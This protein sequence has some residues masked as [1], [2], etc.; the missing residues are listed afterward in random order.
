MDLRVTHL[1]CL[2]SL[3]VIN[4]YRK[5]N[6]VSEYLELRKE[7]ERNALTSF[8]KVENKRDKETKSTG[9]ELRISMNQRMVSPF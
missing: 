2:D 4:L 9:R 5:L 6:I 1:K 8:N 3:E 7:N